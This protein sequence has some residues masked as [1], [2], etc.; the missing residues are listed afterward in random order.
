MELKLHKKKTVTPGDNIYIL[1][2][3][4]FIQFSDLSFISHTNSSFRIQFLILGLVHLLWPV[5][6][7]LLT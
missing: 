1:L 4:A 5:R 6:L 2:I 3:T 7:R